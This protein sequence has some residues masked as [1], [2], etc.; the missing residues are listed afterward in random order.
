MTNSGPRTATGTA[1]LTLRVQSKVHE[2]DDIVAF[3]LVAAAG[4]TLPGFDAGAHID[5]HAGPAGVRQYSLCNPSCSPAHYE[6][7]VLKEPGSRG[8]SKFMHEQ[9]QPGAEVIAGHPKNHFQLVDQAPALLLA[10]GIGITPMVAMA[11]QLAR[12]NLAF[13]L[14]YCAR[15]RRRAAFVEQ[16][17]HK[18]L[19]RNVHLHFD[20]EGKDQKLDLTDVLAQASPAHH[21]Y[22]CGPAGFIQHCVDSALQAGWGSERLHREFFAGPTEP[23]THSP[24]APFEIVLASNGRSLVVPAEVSALSVLQSAGVDVPSSC[25]MGV[26]GTCLLRVLE[27]TPDHRDLYMTEEEQA[28]NDCFTP[29]CSRALTKTLIVDL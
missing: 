27:G 8:G 24:D 11:R 6:I 17:S 29:C 26:C 22:V 12:A 23:S 9:L 1:P 10:G 19:V 21:L 7:A 18:S 2:A 13:E 4:G 28:R 3:R 15:S 14:H 25:E 5:V 16:L 20:D